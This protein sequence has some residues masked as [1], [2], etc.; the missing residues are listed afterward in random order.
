MAYVEDK[1]VHLEN[2][3]E[4][5]VAEMFGLTVAADKTISEAECLPET[6]QEVAD[7]INEACVDDLD[8]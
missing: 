3:E 1:K 5:D 8:T 4:E 2:Q 7:S 6:P